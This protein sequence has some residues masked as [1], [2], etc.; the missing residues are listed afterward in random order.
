M[1][2]GRQGYI[3]CPSVEESAALDVKAAT[4]TY[5]ELQ[6]GPFHLFRLGLLHGR[7]DEAMKDEVMRQFRGGEIQ[8]L[9][10]TTVIEVGIDVP[11]ATF[12]IVEHAE[13]LG[14]SQLHQLRGRVSRGTTAGECH[15]F[16]EPSNEEG[17][18]RLQAIVRLRDGSGWPKRIYVNAASANSLMC[19]S[20]D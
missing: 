5:A 16:A 10:C 17:K 7:Q 9:V 19:G 3:V 6:A 15:L 18:K 11:N 14:L 1:T 12:L 20:T 4:E 8:L 13:R 2:A